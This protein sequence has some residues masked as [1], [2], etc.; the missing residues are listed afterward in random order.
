MMRLKMA[1]AVREELEVKRHLITLEE[2]ERMVGAGVFD[3]ESQIELFRGE[4][5]DMPP[6]GPEHEDCVTFLN[7]FLIRMFHGQA[8]LWPQGNSLRLP[9][10]DSRLQPDITLL[11]WRDD[12]YRG[13]GK[14]PS[15]DDVLLLIEVAD[16]SLKF[17]R[18][19][20]LAL[21]AEAGIPEYWV[22]NLKKDV[23]EV[24]TDPAEGKYQ[25]V[26]VAHRGEALQLPGGLEGSIA[27]SDVLG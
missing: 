23:I 14:R 10:T 1:V 3:P 17:D 12:L 21:Y 5:V 2:Y 27:V 11:R 20:K 25:T 26:K 8:L 9:N 6:P 4:I 15:A 18:G 19:A 16:T 7:Q 22:V 13:R 24:Y